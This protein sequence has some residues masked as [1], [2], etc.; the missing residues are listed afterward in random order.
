MRPVPSGC[1]VRVL[2]F[3]FE[4]KRD[5]ELTLAELAEA[6]QGQ[7]FVWIDVS[8]ADSGAL[9]PWLMSLGLLSPESID[10]ALSRPAGTQVARHEHY[11]HFVV[12]GCEL[13]QGGLTLQR[14]DCALA[15]HFLLTLHRGPV[16]FLESARKS[17]RH[18][19]TRFARTP[20][21]LVYELWDQLV[22]TYLGVQHAL[23]GRVELVQAQLMGDADDRVFTRAAELGVELLHFRKLV[24]AARDAL[25]DLGTRRSL[26][27][28]DTTQRY[29]LNL[30]GTLQNG[31]QELIVDRDI[32]A[33]ALNL[34]MSLVAHRTNAVMKKLTV[35]S[36]VFL[37]LTFL[38][39]V[40]GMNFRYLPELQWR[41]GY[42]LFWLSALLIVAFIVWLSRRARLW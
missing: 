17:Y 22:E 24:L 15:G 21:F 16:Q 41:Q 14:V 7:S 37:P 27:L 18:D 34:H 23:E 12:S 11:V 13:V 10:E 19:F 26:F 30:A 5:V 40:Y 31:L 42:A 28:S 35:V 32:L 3:D 29:L 33:Q 20:S 9:S 25:N 39:G 36:I 1:H 2:G 6:L 4:R 8:F 38:C